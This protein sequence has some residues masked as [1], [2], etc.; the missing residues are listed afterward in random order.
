MIK[1]ILKIF[2]I[3]ILGA[4]GGL[5]FQFF[6]FPYL[7][8]SPY[9]ENFEFIKIL[10]ERQVIINPKEE[11]IVQ[12]NIALEKAIEKVE[13]SLVGVKTKTKEG[14]ILEGSGF[15]ISSDGLMVTLSDLLP[16]GSEINFFVGGETLHLVDGEG[17]I[18]KRDS[19]QNLV[20]VKLEKESLITC[21]FADPEKIKL[22]ERVF[23]V[24]V[25]FDKKEGPQKIVNE[26]IIKIFSENYIKTNIFEKSA[27]KGSPLFDI[28]GNFLGLNTIDSEGRVISIP[29]AKIK[30]FAG[31]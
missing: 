24:G 1:K 27:L 22:G 30:S 11:I 21:G 25:I 16:A 13:K 5:I 9:F 6:L 19:T 20:L 14:K 17:K 10:K 15:I 4:F 12:E 2:A 3:L 28:G 7:I 23:L 18:L 29:V 26:G 8:T 31:F